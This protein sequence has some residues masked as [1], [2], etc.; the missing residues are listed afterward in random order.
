MQDM[1]DVMER[2]RNALKENGLTDD[3]IDALSADVDSDEDAMY[4][5]EL[6]QYQPPR[7]TLH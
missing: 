4:F 5:L 6:P 7:H 1:D 2:L 3:D